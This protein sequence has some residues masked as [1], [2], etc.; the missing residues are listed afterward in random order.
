MTEDNN[1]SIIPIPK[2]AFAHSIR[3]NAKEG[4]GDYEGATL[5]RLK[6]GGKTLKM[7]Y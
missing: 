5:G 1:T 2:N 4:T 6:L 7:I 3:G